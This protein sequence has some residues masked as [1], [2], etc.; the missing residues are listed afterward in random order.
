MRELREVSKEIK[1]LK[2]QRKLNPKEK[3]LENEMQIVAPPTKKIVVI[4][5]TNSD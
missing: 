5:V 4:T 1:R 3:H 2:R